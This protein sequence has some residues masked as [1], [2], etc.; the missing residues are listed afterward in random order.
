[1][2]KKIVFMTSILISACQLQAVGTTCIDI[3]GLDQDTITHPTTKKP[4]PAYQ[5]ILEQIKA[6][7]TAKKIT[8]TTYE[9]KTIDGHMYTGPVAD[10]LSEELPRVQLCYQNNSKTT[11]LSNTYWNNT[12]SLS[13]TRD[14]DK[15]VDWI[16]QGVEL[17]VS[18]NLVK[19]RAWKAPVNKASSYAKASSLIMV[20]FCR[21]REFIVS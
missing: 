3:F 5:Y 16:M 1:M 18:N 4:I 8:I 7:D 13:T 11:Y 17:G 14:T 2:N 19:P 9:G 21:H 12:T 20:P 6:K 15:I 10:P